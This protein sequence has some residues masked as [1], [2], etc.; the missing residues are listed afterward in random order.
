MSNVRQFAASGSVADK[1]YVIKGKVIDGLTFV[2]DEFTATMD[3]Q[4]FWNSLAGLARS[5]KKF[6]ILSY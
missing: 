3:S 4:S 5:K 2:S 6:I 1:A